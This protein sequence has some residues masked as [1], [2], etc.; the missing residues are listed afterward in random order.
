MTTTLSAHD[1]RGMLRQLDRIEDLTEM[2][3][4]KHFDVPAE[5]VYGAAGAAARL[6]ETLLRVCV[7]DVVVE[8]E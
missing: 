3:C 4:H 1:I 2:L 8:V 6:R 7:Q 5:R